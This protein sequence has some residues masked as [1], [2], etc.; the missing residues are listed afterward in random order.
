MLQRDRPA[1]HR[2]KQAD[3][4][5]VPDWILPQPVCLF[6][7]CFCGN[8]PLLRPNIRLAGAAGPSMRG[9]RGLRAGPAPLTLDH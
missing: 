5:H 6:E 4:E 3:A 7:E 2:W 8:V 9:R 1:P